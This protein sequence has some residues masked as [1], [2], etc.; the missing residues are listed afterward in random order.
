[1]ISR[2]SIVFIALAAIIPH[3]GISQ[4]DN[5]TLDRTSDQEE[6]LEAF[7]YRVIGNGGKYY[8][9]KEWRTTD[10]YFRS[11]L[12]VKDFPVRY[13]IEFNLLEIQIGDEIKVLPIGKLF[14]YEFLHAETG[15][16]IVH[17]SGR[18]FKTEHGTPVSGLCEIYERGEWAVITNINYSIKDPDYIKELDV[19]NKD[20]RL[21]LE[22]DKFL[23]I[24]KIAYP[25]TTKKKDLINIIGRESSEAKSYL[26]KEKL[27]PRRIEDLK[28]LVNYL[29]GDI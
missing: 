8:L 26:E 23:C 13:D 16:I 4:Q 15:R 22:K 1:M 18:D 25:L 28:V 27:N 24:N 21:F 29:D 5:R 17:G 10:I 6:V 19:G 12:V 11:G 7:G 2:I 3:R 9:D 14:K 20:E